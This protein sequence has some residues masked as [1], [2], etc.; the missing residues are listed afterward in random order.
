MVAL[1]Y[2]ILYLVQMLLMRAGV[3]VQ[4]IITMAL[5]RARVARVV[6]VLGIL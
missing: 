2:T 3:G 1:V 4:D 6:A 5:L